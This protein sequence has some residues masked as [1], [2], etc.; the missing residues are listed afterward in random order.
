MLTARGRD[1]SDRCFELERT[2][3]SP[4]LSVPGNVLRVKTILKKR[5]LTNEG[6][7]IQIGELLMN[8]DRHSVSVL[9]KV[10][11][12]LHRVQ[13]PCSACFKKRSGPTREHLLN[14]VGYTTKDMPGR[15]THIRRL[16]G[17]TGLMGPYRNPPGGSAIA[18]RRR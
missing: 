7:V 6:K 18:F 14:S 11:H 2:I 5:N 16:T 8:L 1:R 3:M 13:T 10:V 17:E 9:K 12:Y 4:S 15:D